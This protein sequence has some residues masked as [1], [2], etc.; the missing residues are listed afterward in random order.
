MSSEAS[1]LSLSGPRKAAALLITLGTEAS[2]KLLAR[3]P[4]EASIASLSS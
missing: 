1:A 2:A 4:P 3:L